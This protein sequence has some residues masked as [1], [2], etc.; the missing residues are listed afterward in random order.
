ML[1]RTFSLASPILTALALPALA[2]PPA[3]LDACVKLSGETAKAANVQ[4]EAEYV[5]FHF[6]LMDLYAACGAKDFAGAEKIAD[7]IRAAF[8]PKK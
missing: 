4:S 3:D 1:L 2:E 5:K 6:K 7:E 8:P